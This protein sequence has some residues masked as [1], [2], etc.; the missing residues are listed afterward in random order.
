MSPNLWIAVFIGGGLGSM[1]RYGVTL[2]ML[3]F[4]ERATPPWATL[5]SNIVA[6]ALLAFL[7]LRADIDSPERAGAKALLVIGFCGGFSTFS[8][9][10]YE[11]FQFVRDGLYLAAVANILVSVLA[12][13]AAILIIA[14]VS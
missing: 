2:A 12:C 13:L 11:N 14:R 3:R 9:F 8:A 6:S 10:S 7:L 5:T 4:F 1:A